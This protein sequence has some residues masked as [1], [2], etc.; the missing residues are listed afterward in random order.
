MAT[1]NRSISFTLRGIDGRVDITYEVNDD[2]TRWG[3]DLLGFNMDIAARGFP[4]MEART[5]YPAQGYGGLLGWIQVVNYE[6][7]TDSTH[8]TIWAAPDLAPHA[9][10]ASTPYTTFGIE[11]VMFDAPAS[12]DQ[13]VNWL[14]R[15]FLAYTPDC[16]VSPVAEPVCG[17]TWGYD[18]ENGSVSLK[19]LRP[20]VANDWAEITKMLHTR[21]PTWTFGGDEWKPLDFDV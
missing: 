16:L 13:N 12:D 3:F 5:K 11:P 20:S 8:E 21:L 7:K 17:F 19:D 18:I 14:A 9:L 4:V 2:P 15:T 10:E 1:I 6:V